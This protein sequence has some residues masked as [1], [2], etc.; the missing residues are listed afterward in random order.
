MWT[1]GLRKRIRWIVSS[2]EEDIVCCLLVMV[3]T[4]GRVSEWE[5]RGGWL[6]S[7]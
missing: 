5:L 3:V 2:G 4:V 7:R 6:R 1:V